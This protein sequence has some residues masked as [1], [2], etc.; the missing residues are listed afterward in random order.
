MSRRRFVAANR[1]RT[2]VSPHPSQ[3][4]SGGSIVARLVAALEREQVGRFLDET[5]LPEGENLL[6]ADTLDVE[7][8]SADEMTQP[9]DGLRRTDQPARTAA[10]RLVLLPDRRTPALGAHVGK[11]EPLRALRATLLNDRQDLGNDVARAL[12]D[13][14]IARPH[15]L[16]FDLVFVV[17]RGVT[18]D[19]A[20]HGHRLESGHRRQCA[21]APDLYVD[22]LEDGLRLFGG[23]LVSHRPARR[24][25]DHAQPVLPI[26]PVDLVND[27]V[28][29]EGQCRPRFLE[30]PIVL[31]DGF[32]GFAPPGGLIERKAPFREP[33]ARFPE[34]VGNGGGHHAPGISKETDGTDLGYPGIQLAQTSRGR[35]PGIGERLFFPARLR[36][37]E[38]Q[39]ILA[40]HV[41]LAANLQPL[42]NLPPV[43]TSAERLR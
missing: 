22:R 16:A 38:G 15:V 33:L 29:I 25:A 17:E 41:D 3:S 14:R 18:D 23:E 43:S 36:F 37:V 11:L 2:E 24:P 4:C 26:E 31:E 6:L 42:R 1:L 7:G 21:R 20:A 27:T 34:A 12:Y 30:D 10:R 28:D 8:V 5:V 13:D 40:P 39:E 9:L 35:V 32:Q 19:D